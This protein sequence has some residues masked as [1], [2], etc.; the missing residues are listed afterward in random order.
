MEI[1][2]YFVRV[3]LEHDFN[4]K[5][6]RAGGSVSL[7]VVVPLPLPQNHLESIGTPK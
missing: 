2:F 7:S 3:S 1:N 5:S 4:P 6:Q